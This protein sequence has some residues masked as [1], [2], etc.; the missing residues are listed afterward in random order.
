[1][2]EGKVLLTLRTGNMPLLK[3]TYSDELILRVSPNV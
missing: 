3:G 1:M 2:G